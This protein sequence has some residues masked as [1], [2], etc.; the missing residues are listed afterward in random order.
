MQN[1]TDNEETERLETTKH[2]RQSEIDDERARIIEILKE[3]FPRVSLNGQEQEDKPTNNSIKQ[4]EKQ[5]N[6]ATEIMVSEPTVCKV[7]E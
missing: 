4:K 2:D 6:K 1:N 3:H 7:N 5:S